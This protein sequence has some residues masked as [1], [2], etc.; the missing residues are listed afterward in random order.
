[1]E[2]LRKIWG[3]LCR[4]SPRALGTILGVG[5]AAGAIFLLVFH[6]TMSATNSTTICIS[7]HEMS[8]VYDEYKKSVHYMNKSGVRAECS[9]C[10]VPHGKTFPDWINKIIAK[11]NI[12]SKDLWH[13]FIGTYN[14]REKFEKA[15]PE[16]AA[17]V[18]AYMKS[19]DSKE[20]RACH[21]FEAMNIEEQGR[22]AG[23]KHKAAMEG[24][25]SCI[26]CHTGIAHKS[27][28]ELESAAASKGDQG[29]KKE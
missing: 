13:H 5:F 8:G 29:E 21:N 2:F 18:I 9:D 7:C 12:G 23:K 19:R 17:S 4:P 26:D 15:R 1:M 20:C 24:G 14:T 10:H 6:F 25:K 3:L 16:L 28:E 11:A 27:P 22:S